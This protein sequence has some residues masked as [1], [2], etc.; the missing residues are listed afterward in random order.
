MMPPISRQPR[1]ITSCGSCSPGTP[2][3]EFVQTS[4]AKG[5]RATGFGSGFQPRFARKHR[6]FTLLEVMFAMVILSVGLL[7]LLVI[8]QRALLKSEPVE[9]ETRATLLA[10]SILDGIRSDP[11]GFPF[12]PGV[13]PGTWPVI[14]KGG[15]GPDQPINSIYSRLDTLLLE[16]DGSPINVNKNIGIKLPFIFS[17]PGDGLD[18]DALEPTNQ[19]LRG[20]PNGPFIDENGDG[21]DDDHVQPRIGPGLMSKRD[22]DGGIES[23][24][25]GYFM[26]TRSNSTTL[27]TMEMG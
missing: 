14:P 8:L 3:R 19:R 18:N 5:C 6:G 22:F 12:I 24:V 1:F 16:E 7:F 27:T 4:P 9:F 13:N 2:S 20:A 25:S 26:Q 15:N 23:D 21:T 11:G 10:Q 17:V